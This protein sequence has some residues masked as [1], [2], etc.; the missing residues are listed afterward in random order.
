M[1]KTVLITGASSGIG[2]A[3]ARHFQRNGWQV[4]ATMRK[5]EQEHELVKLDNVICVKLD[6]LATDSIVNAI[7]VG[8]ERFGVIDAVVNNAGYGLVGAF[9]ASTP[10]QVERQFATNVFG[11]MNVTRALLPHFRKRRSGIIL[12]VAS[13]GGRIT[14][15]LYSVYHATKWAVEGFSESLQYEVRQFNIKV[16]IIEPGPIKTDFYH[17]SM[18]LISQ[19]GLTE[20]DDFIA[21]AMPNMQKAGESGAAPERVAEVIYRAATDDSWRMRYAANAAMIL[22]LRRVLP[23][24]AFQGIVR[25]VVLG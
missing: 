20:Y 15:P 7:A 23:D 1:S 21:K 4:I 25:K 16:K 10:Q 17:R 2:Q 5:P 19:P 12:N 18:D 8:L 14:F 11:L 9:E 13:M 6:V 24:R 22:G 3:A